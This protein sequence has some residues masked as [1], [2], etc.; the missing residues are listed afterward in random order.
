LYR[1]YILNN[2]I[3]L[4]VFRRE[5]YHFEKFETFSF[6]VTSNEKIGCDVKKSMKIVFTVNASMRF[7][8][9]RYVE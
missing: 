6:N 8:F 5:K 2:K 4:L 9:L 3:L 1:I 7:D